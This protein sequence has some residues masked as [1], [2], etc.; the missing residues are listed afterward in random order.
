MKAI[1]LISS[2]MGLGYLG[3]NMPMQRMLCWQLG[4]VRVVLL[5]GSAATVAA[6]LPCSL[7]RKVA[8]D[9]T[10]SRAPQL[11]EILLKPA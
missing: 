11:P 10:L 8:K 3:R 1:I 2:L 9:D 6:V 5:G 4:Q 7:S